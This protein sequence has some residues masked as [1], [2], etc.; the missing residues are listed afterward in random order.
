MSANADDLDLG[1]PLPTD[2]RS[3]YVAVV[4][5]PNVGK[6]TL[7]NLLLGEKL[8]IVSP[9]PQTT[10]DRQLGILTRPDSQIVFVDTPGI[11]EAHSKLG[12]HMV[13]VATESIPNADL[14]LLLIDVSQPFDDADRAIAEMIIQK[15]DVPLVVALNKRDLATN[16]LVQSRTEELK[17]VA[18]GAELVAISA[19]TGDQVDALLARL[20]ALL[21]PG[22]RFY[23]EDQLT[24]THLR[25]NAAEIIREKILILLADEI[26]HSVAVMV[27]EFKERSETM[28]YI[29]ATIYVEKD[30][31]KGILIGKKGAMLKRIGEKARPDLEQLLGT[32]VYLELWIKVMKNWRRDERAL[33]RL[34]YYRKQ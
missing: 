20:I 25:D 10:R 19:A 9:K 5:K 27:D 13:E 34:G 1:A 16:E 7:M 22:P 4:G 28:T 3:G 26:P 23:P 31:Q 2:H 18:P 14:V 24:E 21:P 12:R 8:A 11:H 15:V 32:S 33:R 6:S 29:A 30:S 17:S